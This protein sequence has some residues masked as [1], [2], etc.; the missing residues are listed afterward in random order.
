MS[1][2]RGQVRPLL[3]RAV[4]GIEG[5]QTDDRTTPVDEQVDE[6]GADEAGGACDDVGGTAPT[7]TAALVTGIFTLVY[8]EH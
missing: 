7:P 3:F 6:M 2:G 8:S 4:G 5:V 1:A